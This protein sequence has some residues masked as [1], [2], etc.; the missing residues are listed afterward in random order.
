MKHEPFNE[1]TEMYL[2]TVRELSS[3][4][5]LVPIS[6][7]AKRLGVSAVSATEMVHR[8]EEQGYLEHQPY[9]GIQLTGEGSERA[10][11]IVRS[12]QL[13]ECFLVD[14]L[15]VP[16][17]DAHD[18]ACRLE[19][20][21]DEAVT[22]A[23]D[24]FLGHPQ[25]CPHGNAIPPAEGVAAPRRMLCLSQLQPG[26]AATVE[27]IFPEHGKLLAYLDAQGLR[28]GRRLVL[29]EIAPFGG[30][31]ILR[32]ADTMVALGD[33]ALRHVFVSLADRCGDER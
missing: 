8:L 11:Q 17:A 24:V 12:H 25:R 20:A 10:I 31:M 5:E 14:Y 22:T 3:V 2:K 26:Q 21:T 19:H 28:P 33:E 30:P 1:S 29:Q 9:K 4:D 27:A 32:V 13:W 23:L 15:H 7:L 6:A 18:H 16:W